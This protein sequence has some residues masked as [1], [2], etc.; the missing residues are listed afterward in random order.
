MDNSNKRHIAK[1]ITALCVANVLN[2]NLG[3]RFHSKPE[4]M[5]RFMQEAMDRIY[6]VLL[7]MDDP[8]FMRKLALYGSLANNLW[9]EPKEVAGLLESGFVTDVDRMGQKDEQTEC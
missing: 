5:N 3:G 8:D 6:S 2:K 4:E 7:R 1:G 9:G